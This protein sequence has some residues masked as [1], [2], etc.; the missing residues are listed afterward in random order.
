MLSHT[1]LVAVRFGDLA[2]LHLDIKAASCPIIGP[3]PAQHR[4]RNLPTAL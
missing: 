1:D 2:G 4:A 3:S